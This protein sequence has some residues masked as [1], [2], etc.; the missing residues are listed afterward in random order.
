MSTGLFNSSRDCLR[1]A[2]PGPKCA[3][4]ARLAADWAAG[5]LALDTGAGVELIGPPGRPRRPEL[6][7]AARVPRRRL[8]SVAGRAALV[9]AIAHIEFNAINLALDAVYRFRGMPIEYYGDWLSVAA[10]EARHFQ[11]LQERLAELGFAYGDFPAHNGLWEMAEQT[12]DS[13]LVRMA[14]VPRVLEARGLDVTP[15]MI[16]RLEVRGDRE[17]VAVLELIL[18]EEVRHV[19]IGSRWFRH[20]C[21]QR[22]LDPER[23]FAELVAEHFPRGLG[24]PFNLPARRAAGFSE[25]ELAA[26]AGAAAGSQ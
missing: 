16:A 22:G 7:D 6:V 12:A 26:L 24:G 21:E 19:A 3:A 20:L 1:L 8:G 5:N 15:G 23:C 11:L 17:T 14:L 18:A 4:V 10:D 13:C 2:E 9:H 25:S